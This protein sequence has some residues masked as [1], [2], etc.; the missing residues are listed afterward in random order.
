M[1]SFSREELIKS[2][3][4]P[5][6]TLLWG[7]VN[8][9]SDVL[10]GAEFFGGGL[11]RVSYL[12]A[13]V[14]GGCIP[15]ILTISIKI[16]TEKYLKKRLFVIIFTYV[17]ESVIGKIGVPLLTFIF[18]MLFDIGAII[19]QIVKVQEDETSGFERVILI[20]SDPIVYWT[21]YWFIFYFNRG[22]KLA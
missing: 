5:L 6:I 20:L 16:H 22:F 11:F 4:C 15:I 14:L 12:I 10:W 19:Y 1:V 3:V 13:F 2:L 9:V 8:A 7:L 18:L 17:A 21:I